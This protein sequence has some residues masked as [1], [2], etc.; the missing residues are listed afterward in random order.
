ML[1][2][3]LAQLWRRLSARVDDRARERH[4]RP[5]AVVGMSSEEMTHAMQCAGCRTSFNLVDAGAAHARC[6]RCGSWWLRAPSDSTVLEGA[7]VALFYPPYSR[8]Q[9]KR[10]ST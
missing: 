6:D 1:R 2:R 9:R 10:S 5:G 7:H 8:P 3:G 4:G